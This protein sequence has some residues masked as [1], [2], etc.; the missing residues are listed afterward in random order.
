MDFSFLVL[1]LEHYFIWH[2]IM[3][4]NLV[5][6]LFLLRIFEGIMSAMPIGMAVLLISFY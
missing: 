6:V 1:P 2:Y 3:Q 5:G 4:L